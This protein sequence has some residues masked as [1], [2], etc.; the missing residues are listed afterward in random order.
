MSICDGHFPE[1][2]R[3]PFDG[4]TARAGRFVS[5]RICERIKVIFDDLM[6]R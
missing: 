5:T 1:S 6:A 4:C 3:K 2:G